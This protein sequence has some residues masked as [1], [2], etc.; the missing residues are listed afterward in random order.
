MLATRWYILSMTTSSATWHD[1]EKRQRVC[2]EAVRGNSH[3]F[4]RVE[5]PLHGDSDRV[6]LDYCNP[7]SEILN[8]IRC[9]ESGGRNVQR[10]N[11]VRSETTTRQLVTNNNSRNDKKVTT[12]R[13]MK[14]EKN[15]HYNKSGCRDK[16][17]GYK[18]D[19]RLCS[20]TKMLRTKTNDHQSRSWTLSAGASPMH[21]MR[22]V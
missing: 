1:G 16:S 13:V 2:N 6:H 4:E 22:R 7:D 9:S 12:V 18:F 20:K 21:P 8:D 15:M 19:W 11:E 17:G 14:P 10:A 3:V 5:R